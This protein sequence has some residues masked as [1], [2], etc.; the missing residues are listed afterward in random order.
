MTSR[1]TFFVLGATGGTGKRFVELALSQ[2][3]TVRCLVRNPVKM[4]QSA[5]PGKLEV[6]QG[7]VVDDKVDLNPLVQGADY[8]VI[9]VG[10]REVQATQMICLPFV[11]RLVPCMRE[12]G[13]KRLLFQ[14][15]GFSRPYGGSLSPILWILRHTLA[16]SYD[17]QHRDNEAV[18]EYLSTEAMDIEWMVHRAGIGGDGESKGRLERAQTPSIAT[19]RDVAA[20]NLT[21]L[22]DDTAIHTMSC[23]QYAK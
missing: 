8:V 1:S 17:G 18:M 11:R 16:R 12:H 5:G 2:G 4:S 19:F 20:Y 15:G 13:V 6:V 22:M 23:S 9:M 21:A 7:S 3:H 10:E 14:A